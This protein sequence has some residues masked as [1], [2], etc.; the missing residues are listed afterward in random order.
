[1]VKTP[2]QA[3]LRSV[4]SE[5]AVT[6]PDGFIVQKHRPTLISVKHPRAGYTALF[7]ASSFTWPNIHSKSVVSLDVTEGGLGVSSSTSG[8]LN[9]WTSHNGETRRQLDGHIDTIYSSCFFPSGTVIL[10]GGSDFRLKIWSAE[11]GQC[12][13]TLTG[14]C[15]A[16]NDALPV[17]R[18]RNVVSAS[19][20][21]TIKLWDVGQSH[22]LHSFNELGIGVI[23][24]ISLGMAD[25][26]SGG[27]GAAETEDREVGTRGKFVIAAGEGIDDGGKVAGLI[28]KS[29]ETLFISNTDAPANDC[30][31]LSDHTYVYGLQDGTLAVMDMRNVSRTLFVERESRGAVLNLCRFRS[32]FLA[33][34]QDGSVVY[35]PEKVFNRGQGSEMVLE[36]TG[37]EVDPV[38]K[39]A[40]QGRNSIFTACRDGCIRKYL[41]DEELVSTVEN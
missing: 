22:C 17:E 10:T 8:D 23:N 13:A 21:G 27:N 5:E 3:S 4:Y 28:L 19:R 20:D 30:L 14:H 37:P 38:Y 12:A 24:G 6:Q 7:I 9:V 33:A 29:R 2:G 11:T 39:V 16:V 1:M 15:G 31:V 40:V 32:G 18:G 36:L 26:F 41:I 35:I 25:S 34:T